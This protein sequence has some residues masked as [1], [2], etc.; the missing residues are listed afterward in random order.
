MGGL[1]GAKTRRRWRGAI[2]GVAVPL[3]L[4]TANCTYFTHTHDEFFDARLAREANEICA[5]TKDELG[6]P[7]TYVGG[8]FERRAQKVE[9]LADSLQAMTARLRALVP[10]GEN[11]A[12]DRWIA[13]LD[14]MIALGRVYARAIRTGDPSI[15][16]PA[17]NLGDAPARRVNQM[18]RANRMPDCIF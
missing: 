5:E 8:D 13:H 1:S 15:Y 10:P 11:E 14:E 17:G 9:E 3:I 2:L 16:E 12:F 7:P 18:A 6:E 4:V